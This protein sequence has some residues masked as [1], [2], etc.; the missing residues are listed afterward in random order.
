[1]KLLENIR[2]VQWY[3]FQDETMP[4]GGSCILLGDNGSGKTTVLDA[5]QIALVA[6]FSEILLNR[7]ANEKS[8][9][10][11]YGY[12]RWK[13]GSEDE[14]RPGEVRYGRR[15]CSSYV[16]LEF[17][18]D[19][20][21][22]SFTCGAGFEATETDTE[23]TKLFFVVPDAKVA[24][25]E[26]VS[27]LVDGQRV[28]RP[29]REVK[30]WLRMRGGKY[31]QDPGTYR[32]ELRQRLGALPESFHR[33]IVKALAFK[34]IGQVRQFVFDY[35]L[36]D[37]PINTVALQSNLEHYKRLEGEAQEAEKRIAE[38]EEIVR[39]GERIIT[40]QRTAESHQYME[41][42]ADMESS[43]MKVAELEGEIAQHQAVLQLLLAR[44]KA[45]PEE[46]RQITQELDRL[47][48]LLEGHEVYQH[49]IE[50]ER[51]IEDTRRNLNEAADADQR[52]RKLLLL[53]TEALD[54]LLCE[55]SRELRRL[56]PALF[57]KG[58]LLGAE[59][60]PEVVVRLRSTLASEGALS[61]RDLSIWERQLD[62]AADQSRQARLVLNNEL[63]N[64][65]SEGAEL[66]DEQR[67]L[68]AGRQKYPDGAAALLHLLSTRLKGRREPKPLCELIDV[69]DARWRDAV[70]GY[71][72]TRRYD[73]IVAPEDYPRALSLYER[74]KRDYALPGRGNV[75]I[76]GV[77]LV[78]I[79]RMMRITPRCESRSLAEQVETNDSYAR[80]YSDFVLGNVICV[81][82]EQSLRKHKAS[83]TDTVMVYRNHV[84]RQT[85]RETYSRHYIGEA[86]RQR[87]LEEIA[88]RLAELH[89]DVVQIAAHYKFLE[90]VVPLLDQARAEARRLPDLIGKAGSLEWLKL[91]LRRLG[92]QKNKIDRS[93]IHE[94]E[95][96]RAEGLKRQAVLVEEQQKIEHDSGKLEAKIEQGE[97]E[98]ETKKD[99]RRGRENALRDFTEKRDEQLRQSYEPRYLRERTE[100]SPEQIH[101]VFEK[102]RRTIETR[103]TNLVNDLVDLK[104]R[105]IERHGV[106]ISAGRA[107]FE[108]FKIELEAWRESKLPLYR[109]KISEAKTKA[110]QQLAEDIVFRLRENLLLVR[111]QIDDLNRALEDVPFGSEKY[112]FIV[113]V[114]PEHRDFYNLVMD[115]GRFEKESLFGEAAMTSPELRATLGNLLDRLIEAEAKEVKTELEAKA[116]Y[117]EYFRYD[118]KIIHA[119]GHYSLY[120]KVS[121][122]K[123]GGETQTPYYIAILASMYRLYRS[124]SLDDRPLCGVVLLDEAF[125]KMDE[126]RITATLAFA[127]NLRL[128][129]IL[130]TPKERSEMVAPAVERSIF[131][132]KDAISGVPTVLDFTKEFARDERDDLRASGTAYTAAGSPRA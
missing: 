43:Q 89:R 129:L 79:E 65:K 10:A 17:S 113:E 68:E 29:L 26:V 106:M 58:D 101:E 124:R 114:E 131:I 81:D 75:F 34:P 125:G 51:Q 94:L 11:L 70:E 93:Q 69:P 20:G 116:D 66:L 16:M 121:G 128:Q 8:R 72:N 24:D 35:L 126:S 63:N 117:R 18:D 118:L 111:R 64:A 46:L 52:A 61:G 71:L 108:E 39:E 55:Q 84:A 30:T 119:D 56:H 48:K 47:R 22:N 104:A 53:Q 97:N 40:E 57:E 76:A 98:L 92:E 82:D 88:G 60:P 99:E 1:M 54:S 25:V 23:V 62:R 115:A 123:S 36:D 42:R 109:E 50:L 41:L 130:A 33:L 38:L 7:A 77:G 86:A 44:K 28:V 12:V 21:K 3:H 73:V 102:Q 80:L 105:Y 91:Q 100:R 19:Q 6:D 83:I 15:S 49:L 127:R 2:L 31:W 27:C 14:S 74:H 87:R 122:D 132:H 5:I 45:I 9:R 107:E 67:A 112:Q 110:L 4:I 96:N 90:R 120:D 32:E 78:D 37:R 103:V 85:P 59:E 95:D 13:I